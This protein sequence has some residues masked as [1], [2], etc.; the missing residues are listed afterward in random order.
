MFSRLEQVW[1]RY[2]ELTRLLSDPALLGNQDR[3]RQVSKEHS[4]LTPLIH[5]YQRYLKAKS[6]LNGLKEITEES[7]DAEM[8]QLAFGEMDE[9]KAKVAALEEEMG[10]SHPA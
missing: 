7:G 9:A 1:K 3:L 6:D 8:K 10:S 2:E 5:V 4:D